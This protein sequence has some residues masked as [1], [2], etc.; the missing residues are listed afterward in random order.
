MQFGL[1]PISAMYDHPSFYISTGHKLN[2]TL[3][4][5]DNVVLNTSVWCR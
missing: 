5:V 2:E 4:M 1:S 3:T